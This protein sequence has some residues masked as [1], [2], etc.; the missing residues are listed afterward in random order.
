VCDCSVANQSW[1][2]KHLVHTF[3]DLG[4]EREKE[5]ITATTGQSGTPEKKLSMTIANS[6]FRRR[7]GESC[8]DNIPNFSS[9]WIDL[10]PLLT[11]KR[12]HR[13]LAEKVEEHMTKEHQAC[14][15]TTGNLWRRRQRDIALCYHGFQVKQNWRH[16]ESQTSG[17][18]RFAEERTQHGDECIG[19]WCC[20]AEH[21][22]VRGVIDFGTAK[23]DAEYEE[24]QS[25]AEGLPVLVSD[26]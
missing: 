6:V 9:G 2:W 15:L 19:F 18:Q 1:I 17:F 12:T 10:E 20:R 4:Q 24:I 25:R 22:H 23:K 21:G 13:K 7:E 5:H 16:V 14:R 8:L 3:E 11:S 26:L